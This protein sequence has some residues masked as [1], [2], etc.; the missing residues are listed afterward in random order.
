EKG[1]TSLSAVESRAAIKPE[2]EPEEAS[3]ET[4]K[5][6]DDEKGAFVFKHGDRIAGRYEIKLSLGQGTFGRVV[7]AR[8]VSDKPVA[9]GQVAIKVIRS[10]KRYVREARIEAAIL[11]DIQALAKTD[12][13]IVHLF[14]HFSWNDRYCLVLEPLGASLHDFQK[15]CGYRSMRLKHIQVVARD[16]FHALT[17]LHTKCRIAH[18]DLK[19]E[20]VLFERSPS[21]AYDSTTLVEDLDVFRVKLVDFGGATEI[22]R[23]TRNTSIVSTRQYRAPEV[24]LELGWSYP[25]DVWSAGCILVELLCTKL[26]FATHEEHEH[27]ALIEKII[28]P[29]P[30]DLRE[31]CPRFFDHNM[32]LYWPV[33]R[34]SKSRIAFVSRART[35]SELIAR[36]TNRHTPKPAQAAIDSFSKLVRDCLRVSPADRIPASDAL[37]A[38]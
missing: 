12:S 2:L 3:S 36:Y 32:K 13:R 15:A 37:T 22:R 9:A 10:I 11:Q 28:E 34:T 20:N 16:I 1:S 26:L 23:D 30:R 27:L 6:E 5:Q 19:L 17:F 29:F 24:T 21:T 14:E 31:R 38:T 25:S 8:D 18:T 33:P 4:A 35:L 7:L